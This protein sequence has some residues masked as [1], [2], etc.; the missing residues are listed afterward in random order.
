MPEPIMQNGADT[1]KDHLESVPRPPASSI[2]VTE[3]EISVEAI[4][5]SRQE[6]SIV[7]AKNGT[8]S[9]SDTP[10]LD[11]PEESQSDE[12]DTVE[13]AVVEA[14]KETVLEE[15]K[16]SKEEEPQ[17]KGDNTDKEVIKPGNS[18]MNES[19]L[20]PN[21][22]KGENQKKKP[23]RPRKMD[24]GEKVKK[25][26]GRPRK[27]PVVESVTKDDVQEAE[28]EKVAATGEATPEVDVD[29]FTYVPGKTSD[30]I[31][32]STVS[33]IVS[34]SEGTASIDGETLENS[35]KSGEGKLLNGSK[36]AEVKKL[37]KNK[38]LSPDR[39]RKRKASMDT[40][41]QS[42]VKKP[43]S[44]PP[45]ED[46]SSSQKQQDMNDF[47]DATQKAL[48]GQETNGV[49]DD[50]EDGD[51]SAS[52]VMAK[53]PCIDSDD[54]DE[55]LK[56]YL[57][58]QGPAKPWSIK[59]KKRKLN[60]PMS[61]KRKSPKSPENLKRLA[62]MATM[63]NS[64]E[65]LNTSFVGEPEVNDGAASHVV[66]GDSLGGE[67]DSSAIS[68]KTKNIVKKNA[69]AV[70]REQLSQEPRLNDAVLDIHNGDMIPPIPDSAEEFQSPKR[71]S[72]K[73]KAEPIK[74]D[75]ETT[76]GRPVE[77]GKAK[78]ENTLSKPETTDVK[79]VNKGN[80]PRSKFRKKRF[81]KWNKKKKHSP[82]VL[83]RLEAQLKA[84]R[85]AIA[86]EKNAASHG[87]Q[88]EPSLVH[89]GLMNIKKY[90]K[91]VL[92]Q[93]KSSQHNSANDGA[94]DVGELLFSTPALG[95]LPPA[96]QRLQV[97]KRGRGRGG[98]MGRGGGLT[99][100]KSSPIVRLSPL[101]PKNDT[102]DTNE[103]VS[104]IFYD[105]E[106]MGAHPSR[107]E[108]PPVLTKISGLEPVQSS[109]KRPKLS[110]HGEALDGSDL[111][112]KMQ[113]KKSFLKPREATEFANDTG[114]VSLKNILPASRRM[115][116]PKKN[117]FVVK[118]SYKRSLQN[119]GMNRG[120]K[121]GYG[122]GGRRGIASRRMMMRPGMAM[123]KSKMGGGV[124]PG[125]LS[126][127]QCSR[128]TPLHRSPHPQ[129]SIL[130]SDPI[131]QGGFY[132]KNVHR[133][134]EGR[135][136]SRERLAGGI[137]QSSPSRDS[138]HSSG[139]DFRKRQSPGSYRRSMS[140]DNDQAS[141]SEQN[142]NKSFSYSP[143]RKSGIGSTVGA[144]ISQLFGD[145]IPR[146]VPGSGYVINVRLD[147][148]RKEAT[149]THKS[150]KNVSTQ[151]DLDYDRRRHHSTSREKSTH[152]SST[153]NSYTRKP[154]HSEP[155]PSTSASP[156]DPYQ[157]E[158]T[159]QQPHI[160]DVDLCA[161][162]EERISSRRGL[163]VDVRDNLLDNIKHVERVLKESS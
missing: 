6:A 58:P 152:V 9:I 89:A 91:T 14:P 35:I 83:Q 22:D 23:G 122:R 126:P 154:S 86:A 74:D 10:A 119:C 129:T 76:A 157:R 84:M 43:G 90:G 141:G 97:A 111:Q 100:K 116:A 123:S 115:T 40:S 110:N 146:L 51:S 87:L 82:A 106:M 148:E 41:S 32:L 153:V 37:L 20:E 66:D 67:T 77:A 163:R 105:A 112:S 4:K 162:L 130:E 31:Q 69:F 59:K 132:G 25:K 102:A 42:K 118:R 70:L 107:D 95:S 155:Q 64:F 143:N 80:S 114:A 7:K 79:K 68:S 93:I 65:A 137:D 1:V 158:R 161:M 55:Q 50:Q 53:G 149:G 39:T 147:V 15:E 27:H 18:N 47:L 85:A 151:E 19:A 160:S 34:G 75:M 109:M 145:E 5:Q 61:S 29:L 125:Q 21:S 144:V 103:S 2:L 156:D 49:A 73:F 12:K 113:A 134:A 38:L 52:N 78:Q 8:S 142:S 150:H 159:S 45:A 44:R 88:P 26:I 101:G 48:S 120:G 140:E 127:D 121:K 136:N 71:R 62:E 96:P 99:T 63:H 139:Q 60:M 92:S 124:D 57:N 11:K 36:H 81:H 131:H 128:G 94:D 135:R 117:A 138:R 3:A 28:V 72:K 16:A 46:S 33:S 108:D 30:P 104:D 24:S 133:R 17:S 13:A 54:D 98:R 56:S